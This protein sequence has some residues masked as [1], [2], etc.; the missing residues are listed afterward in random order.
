LNF[1]SCIGRY[2]CFY[3]R[4]SKSYYKRV[5]FSFWVSV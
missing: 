1:I 2:R 3:F 4:Y 5:T